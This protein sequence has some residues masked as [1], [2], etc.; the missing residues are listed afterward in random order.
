MGLKET[1]ASTNG[2]VEVKVKVKTFLRAEEATKEK[3][4]RKNTEALLPKDK[5]E[6]I[7]T[8]YSTTFAEGS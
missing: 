2:N 1:S 6:K 5:Q 8:G 7:L 4:R 3:R